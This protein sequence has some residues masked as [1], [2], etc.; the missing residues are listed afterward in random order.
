MTHRV[1]LLDDRCMTASTQLPTARHPATGRPTSSAGPLAALRRWYGPVVHGDTWKESA[2]LLLALPT[3][4]AW[5][6]IVVTGLSVSA[7]LLITLVGL[8]LLVLLLRFG[9]VIG[10]VE[11]AASR[12][13]LGLDLRPVAAPSTEGTM[14]ARARRTLGDGPSW[15]ALVYAV[16]SLPVGIIAFTTTV[17]LWSVTA[18]AVTLPAYQAFLSASDAA[19]VPDALSPLLHGWGRAGAVTIVGLVGAVLLALTPRLLHRLAYAHHRL[20]RRWL[21]AGGHCVRG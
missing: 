11:R 10:A 12:A 14:W 17:V 6:T 3:S 4:V 20:V 7:S 13:L 5:S 16:V 19:D 18:A 21:S 9:R 15:K 8:P 1:V 2:A